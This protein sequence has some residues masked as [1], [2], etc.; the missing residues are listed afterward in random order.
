MKYRAMLV[1]MGFSASV[2]SAVDFDFEAVPA[3]PVVGDILMLS[4]QGVNV[5]FSALGLQ[6]RDFGASF[7]N[8]GHVLSSEF[9]SGPITVTFDQA[10]LSVS[11]ENVINGRYSGE[12][13]FID[14]WAYDAANNLVDSVSASAADFITLS[15]SGIVKVVWQEAISGEGFVVDN[16]SFTIPTPAATALLGFG[17][18]VATRRRRA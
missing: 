17:A 15:G 14:A 2:A 10:V 16:V 13:D 1:A 6:V 9:D 12:I 5:T 3:G 8:T 18:L 11:F 4:S 7:G